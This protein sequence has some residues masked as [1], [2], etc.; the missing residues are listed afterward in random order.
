MIYCVKEAGFDQQIHNSQV[1]WGC[2]TLAT[3]RW[4]RNEQRDWT[5]LCWSDG[6]WNDHLADGRVGLLYQLLYHLIKWPVLILNT[7]SAI[8]LEGQDSCSLQGSLWNRRAGLF[9]EFAHGLL[10]RWVHLL[11]RWDGDRP[12]LNIHDDF[13][14]LHLVSG[15]NITFKSSYNR[16]KYWHSSAAPAADCQLFSHVQSHLIYYIYI[17]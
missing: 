14:I 11:R 10:S 15:K 9:P 4:R 2:R 12:Q 3:D 16:F 17:I 5:R 8:E 13:L 1:R 6:H 7:W